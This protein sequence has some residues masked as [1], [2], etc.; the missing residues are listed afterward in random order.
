MTEFLVRI[1]I[2]VPAS[3]SDVELDRLISAEGDRARVLAASGTLQ[4]LWRDPHHWANWGIWSG[5]NT[6]EIEAAIGT[7]PL[8]KFMTVEITELAPHPSDPLGAK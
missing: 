2:D 8:Q 6:A 3:V 4:R 7:L 1:T 5:A